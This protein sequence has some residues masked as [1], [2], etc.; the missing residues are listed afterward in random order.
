RLSVKPV[1]PAAA[2]VAGWR[3]LVRCPLASGRGAGDSLRV[4]RGGQGMRAQRTQAPTRHAR[5]G[6]TLI[7]LLVTLAVASMLVVV[8]VPNF[9][10]FVN[11]SRLA[12]AANEL[13]ASLQLARAEAIRRNG[14][15]GV[16]MSS[17]TAGGDTASCATG[18]AVDGWIAFVDANEDGDYDK[19]DDDTFLRGTMLDGPMGVDVSP[20]ISANKV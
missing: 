15:A 6:F 1:T 2:P 14:R 4:R 19:D 17:G 18:D 13:I 12:G 3:P 10:A 16:C 8:A 7:E 11:S 9:Q 5:R 20:A